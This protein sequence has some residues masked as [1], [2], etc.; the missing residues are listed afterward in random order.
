[1]YPPTLKSCLV[2]EEPGCNSDMVVVCWMTMLLASILDYSCFP[3]EIL[4]FYASVAF[5]SCLQ[6]SMAFDDGKNLL[7]DLHCTYHNKKLSYSFV[8]HVFPRVNGVD[9]KFSW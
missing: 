1:M 8:L 4:C 9:L 5:S 3:F 7:G 2:D 6:I